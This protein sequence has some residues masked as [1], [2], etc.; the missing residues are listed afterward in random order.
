MAP[1]VMVSYKF[2]S[3]IKQVRD[4]TNCP[5]ASQPAKQLASQPNSQICIKNDSESNS[6]S[7]LK[8]QQASMQAGAT[9]GNKKV[10][11]GFD[12]GVTAPEKKQ[13]GESRFEMVFAQ[14][15]AHPIA[16]QMAQIGA[17]AVV[18]ESDE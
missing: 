4:K 14:D 12:L 16:D 3:Q 6:E 9:L 15:S 5:A 13:A 1:G 11:T 17:D 2:P 18:P 8:N 10:H 7:D